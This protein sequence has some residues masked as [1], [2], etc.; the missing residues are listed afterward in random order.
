MS[1]DCAEAEDRVDD[2]NRDLGRAQAA[3]DA[4]D[5]DAEANQGPEL[6]DDG[7]DFLL[8]LAGAG[9]ISIL[10]GPAAFAVATLGGTACLGV[11]VR[12]MKK[13]ADARDEARRRRKAAH[14]NVKDKEQDLSSARRAKRHACG[15]GTDIDCGSRG[16]PGY[17]R[18]DGKCA[19]WNDW[20]SDDE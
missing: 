5:R 7:A 19:G 14:Q 18:P 3:A 20:G 9:V 15:E 4:A 16:G 12:S 13:K 6:T 11:S 8:C 1:D 17:R 2:A 10:T